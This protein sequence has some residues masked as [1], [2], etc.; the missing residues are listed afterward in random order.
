LAT[1][2]VRGF[3]LKIKKAKVKQL[4][5]ELQQLKKI[6]ETKQVEAQ[7][8]IQAEQVKAQSQK[9][10]EIIRQ[11]GR[12]KDTEIKVE[13]SG[14]EKMVTLATQRNLK[15]A[16]LRAELGLKKDEAVFKAAE[17]QAK[18]LDSLNKVRELDYKIKT[19]NQGI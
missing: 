13:A 9:E 8:R 12:L 19:G 17:I 10:I 16:E 14:K 7:G 3:S 5:E 15:L 4:V 18:K 11:Q 6:V 1:A 2:M